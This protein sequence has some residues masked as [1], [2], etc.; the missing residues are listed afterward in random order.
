MGRRTTL[1]LLSIIIAALG[2]AAVALYARN[3]D[4]RAQRD[5]EVV[6][7]YVAREE[8][9]A[10]TTWEAAV[11]S[12]RIQLRMISRAWRSPRVRCQ[13]AT[14]LNGQRSVHVIEQGQQIVSQAF[15]TNPAVKPPLLPV[16]PGNLA[17]SVTMTEAGRV[18]GWIEAG[19]RVTVY[20][21]VEDQP[22]AAPLLPEVRVLAVGNRQRR[23]DLVT[24]DVRPEDAGKL[25]GATQGTL[26]LAL[27]SSPPALG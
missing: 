11:N 2:T 24:L 1:L 16:T 12:N 6:S 3:A 7:V 26:Y 14:N 25:V 22:D 23:G 15:S 10:D 27:L 18:A 21:V 19:S 5:L 13:R 8:V 20:Q 17:I 4:Q 9:P